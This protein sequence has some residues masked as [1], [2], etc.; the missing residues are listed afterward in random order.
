[1]ISLSTLFG[2][3]KSMMLLAGLV[4]IVWGVKASRTLDRLNQE[5]VQLTTQLTRIGQINQQLTQ[6][7]QATTVQL[8]Q[9]QEQERL[10]GEKSSELQKRLR[11]A[12]KGNRCAEE[13]V[14]AAVIRMQQQSFSDGK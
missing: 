5:N 13:P 4:A 3:G 6:H 9:A 10:E 11:L 1:M 8:K 14:P 2:L 7:I 12:Q